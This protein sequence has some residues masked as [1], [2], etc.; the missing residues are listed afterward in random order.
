MFAVFNGI[1]GCIFAFMIGSSYAL[2]LVAYLPVFL[3]ILATF[4]ILVKRSTGDRIESIK[5]MGGIVSEIL[6]AI[7]VVASFGQERHEMTK[8]EEYS[9]RAEQIGKSYQ[10]RFSFMYAIMKFA[11]FSFYTFAF[12]FGTVFISEKRINPRTNKP[13]TAQDVLTILIAL[14]T[15]FIALIAALPHV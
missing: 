2:Y 15:G 14:I 8:F 7:K 9:D 5:E 10:L 1:G 3:F 6:Y 13:Y 12:Y 11:I 4:G